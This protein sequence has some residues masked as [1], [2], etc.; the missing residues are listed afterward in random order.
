MVANVECS[1]FQ[2]CSLQQMLNNL[3]RLHTVP[4]R[5]T[6]GSLYYLK[7]NAEK[8]SNIRNHADVHMQISNHLL[9]S[10]L[11]AAPQSSNSNFS[12]T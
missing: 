1:K 11:A 8:L 6:K 2:T 7:T 12:R 4:S 3:C 10:R 9:I 5:D